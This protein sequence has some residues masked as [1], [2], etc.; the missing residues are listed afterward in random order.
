[1]SKNNDGRELRWSWLGRTS[2][3]PTWELQKALREEIRHGRAPDHFLL[4]EH[5]PVF[6]VGRN[7]TIDDVLANPEW[8]AKH[9]VEVVETNRGGQ[10]TF[11][12]PGQLVGYP[13]INLDP[14]RRDIRR[15]VRDLQEVLIRLLADY[16][17]AA[18]RREGPEHIGVWVGEEPQCAKIASIGIHLARWIT[19]HGF[20][21][22]VDTDLRFFG[23]IVAC[24]LPDVQMTS[25]AQQSGTA[26]ALPDLAEAAVQH[27]AEV[28]GREPISVAAETLPWKKDS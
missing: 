24:G 26:P 13:I 18:R 27:L 5:A 25:I 17:V 28:F 2:Y 16:G 11:H 9:G 12:G 7:A 15:Y 10:V 22:N 20:A 14:D 3:L 1:M 21:L 4:L 19:N 6:T 8:L 23:G